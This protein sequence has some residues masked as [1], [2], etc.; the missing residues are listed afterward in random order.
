MKKINYKK[1]LWSWMAIASTGATTVSAQC[2]VAGTALTENY[3]S[4][5]GWTFSDFVTGNTMATACNG[6]NNGFLQINTNQFRF[7][8]AAGGRELRAFRT[9]PTLSNTN[10]TADFTFTINATPAGGLATNAPSAYLAAFT[11]GTQPI[12]TS[13]AGAGYPA[14]CGAYPATNQDGIWVM[15]GANAPASCVSSLA[16]TNWFFVAQS[17]RGNGAMSSSGNIALT[18]IGTYYLRLQRS[19]SDWGVLSVYSDPNHTNLIGSS[20]FQIDPAIAGLNT[21][22]HGYV[23]QGSQQ[24]ILNASVSNMRVDNAVPCPLTLTPSFTTSSVFCG[25]APITANGT[26]TTGTPLQELYHF[27]E[28]TECDALG[29]TT[30]NPATTWNQWYNGQAG[31]YTFP[32]AANGG[33]GFI[34]C[35]KYYQI[36]LAVQNCGNPW[37]STERIIYISCVKTTAE[38]PE[39]ICE[40][41][42]VTLNASGNASYFVWNPGNITAPS[43]TVSPSTST[44][45][46][47]TGYNMYGCSSSVN[48]NVIVTPANLNLNISTAINDL[49]SGLIPFNG[50]DDT[51]KIRTIPGSINSAPYASLPPARVVTPLVDPFSS[52]YTS[53]NVRWLSTTTDGGGNPVE[54]AASQFD[55]TF[56]DDNHYRF[57]YEFNLLNNY[58][59]LRIEGTEAASDNDVRLFLN[60]WY[61]YGV[62]GWSTTNFTTNHVP[63]TI[64]T[65]QAHYNNG[66]V[67]VLQARVINGGGPSWNGSYMGFLLN[68][69]IKGECLANRSMIIHPADHTSAGI[70]TDNQTLAVYPNPGIGLFMV[71]STGE[72]ISRIVILDMAG[73]MVHETNN[74]NTSKAEIDLQ[75]KGNG[76]YYARIWTGNNAV[77]KTKK[78]IIS[79]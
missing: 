78:I 17:R 68:A 2:N 5:A 52:W 59:N 56:P 72:N 57:E 46:T 43:I 24:R 35:G 13:C 37:T 3:P 22:Q 70:E 36:K 77:P 44:V 28:I 50:N 14:S 41:E 27:W 9:I 65:N 34:T 53:P 55:N 31:A 23:E 79:K 60:N 1:W 25:G 66:G 38:D 8:T 42:Q 54:V 10:W 33:P 45:Y 4:A 51:W 63:G 58:T 30:Y 49:T 29:N 40:G 69:R 48:V 47:V 67:N 20:C 76:V 18:G 39:P 32:S 15:I 64:A 12:R 7:V 11:A 61:E 21:M 73:R 75:G 19:W 6:A 16:E 62:T 71:N 26:A 74:L